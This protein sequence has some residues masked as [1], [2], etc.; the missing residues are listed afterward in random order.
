MKLKCR[1]SIIKYLQRIQPPQELLYRWLRFAVTIYNQFLDDGCMYRAAALTYTCL[2]SLVPLMTVSFAILAAFPFFNKI[3]SELQNFIFSHFIAASGEVIQRYIQHFVA[4]TSNLSVIGFFFLVV[5]AVLLMFNIEQAFNAIWHIRF[6]RHGVSAILLYWAVL[7]LT[8][9]L[10][11]LSIVI[12]GYFMR[13][14]VIA[15]AT[16]NF[17][18]SETIIRL[19][20]WLLSVSTF[21]LL[22]VAVPNC[23]VPLRFGLIGALASGTL[24]ELAKFGFAIYVRNFPTYTLLY[25]ALAT[26]PIFLVWLYTSWIIILFGAVISNVLTVGY[27]YRS[28]DKLDGFTHVYRWLGHF[29]QAMHEAKGLTMHD[30]VALDSSNY[31]VRPDYVIS[32][33]RDAKLIQPA[34]R[35]KF[36]LSVDLS[37]LSLHELYLMLPWRLPTERELNHWPGVWEKTLAKAIQQPEDNLFDTLQ[38][39]LS[40]MYAK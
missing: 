36:V 27:Q 28:P 38:I 19:I 18:I 26:I 34:E 21:W 30:L 17:W 10:L 3:S 29:W 8:P 9:I 39:P 23:T 33:M 11:G 14:P 20:P 6:R 40:K 37:T 7:T 2:L 13:L 35:G 4:Q 22:Y 32:L 31:Q 5:T 16:S 25:G 1:L 15:E 24:F 12:S